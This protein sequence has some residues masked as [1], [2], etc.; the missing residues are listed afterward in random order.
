MGQVGIKDIAREL[1]LDYSTVSYALRGK[2][3]ISATTRGH[4]EAK[5]RE[6]GYVANNYAK[7]MR[8]AGMVN[9][10]IVMP[11]V[12]WGYGILVQNIYRL[13]SG[14][15]QNVTMELTEFSGERESSAIMSLLELRVSGLI[16]KSCHSDLD[17]L[18]ANSALKLALTNGVVVVSHGDAP[19]IGDRIISLDTNI[20]QSGVL[21]GRHFHETGRGKLCLMMPHMPPYARNWE[22][23]L[24]G[25]DAGSKGDAG[26]FTVHPLAVDFKDIAPLVRQK[27]GSDMDYEQQMHGNLMGMDYENGYAVGSRL[28][29]G[30]SR[31][32]A[33]ACLSEMNARGLIDAA[34]DAGVKVPDDLSVATSEQPIFGGFLGKR[35]THASVGREIIAENCVR[36][37]KA[38]A[39]RKGRIVKLE[40]VLHV[41]SSTVH[42]TQS[43]GSGIARKRAFT[44][45]EL[46]VVI[47]IIAILAAML[48]PAL[49]KAVE[50]GRTATC[51]NNLKQTYL[52][53]SN[54][55]NDW[56]SYPTPNCRSADTDDAKRIRWW[57]GLG[58]YVN[59]KWSSLQNEDTDKQWAARQAIWGC[60]SNLDK[61]RVG[62][63]ITHYGMSAAFEYHGSM[64]HHTGMTPPGQ[65][66][67]TYGISPS[68][69]KNN[70]AMLYGDR[71]SQEQWEQKISPSLALSQQP[72]WPDTRHFDM[73]NLV[74]LDGHI[75]KRI[76]KEA[77]DY[78]F[79]LLDKQP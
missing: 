72:F 53:N 9:Y 76:L 66:F 33:V 42:G 59:S 35:I 54:Y 51:L 14:E 21:L 74:H 60:P 19:L 47:A 61:T 4:V 15:S 5:A 78:K 11:H 34:L 68:R 2:G 56:N 23:F 6:M 13:L 12:L 46:L 17:S 64:G 55:V 29:R 1:G 58:P 16:I 63:S 41:G 20:R 10:G 39:N 36:L 38:P 25:L 69:I 75:K 77:L 67:G 37:M 26:I 79:W 45:I 3:T 57:R 32:D 48:L 22:L 28:M 70:V 49:S 44:L 43:R 30:A 52:A 62:K 24:E 18:P 73:A 8:G 31:P 71:R 7:A 65:T 27:E 50:A 40:P